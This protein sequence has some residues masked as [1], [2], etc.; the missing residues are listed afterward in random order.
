MY[1]VVLLGQDLAACNDAATGDVLVPIQEAMEDDG[2]YFTCV[3]CH[4]IL[5]D[6][7]RHS[8]PEESNE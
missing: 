2:R 1:H 5:T 4:R 6:G 8:R 7:R 3:T